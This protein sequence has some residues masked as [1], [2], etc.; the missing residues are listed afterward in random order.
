MSFVRSLRSLR[1]SVRDSGFL[2]SALYALHRAL[3]RFSGGRLQLFAYGLYAQPLGAPALAAVRADADSVVRRVDRADALVA[4]FPRPAA[5]IEGRFAS[6][7]ECY[8]ITVRDEFAGHIWIARG[9]YDEDEVHCRY[10]LAA[11]ARCVWDFDVYVEPRWRLGR[12]MARLWQGVDRLLVG[13]GVR[14]TFSRISLF[15]RASLQSHARLGAVARGWVVFFTAG[16]AQLT[17][18][19]LAPFVHCRWRPGSRPTL[20][21]RPPS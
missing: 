20:L 21:L 5:V 12:T 19:S 3:P 4:R 7:C 6:G 8:T 2:V 13:E 18:S 1:A 17:V 15:N 9:H 10:R 14:W 16:P 11:P